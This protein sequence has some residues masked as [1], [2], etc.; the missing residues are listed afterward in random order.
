MGV[1]QAPLTV[2][3]YSRQAV[4]RRI[5]VRASTSRQTPQIG[6]LPPA[7]S[8]ARS[9]MTCDSFDSGVYGVSHTGAGAACVSGTT[10]RRGENR[11]LTSPPTFTTPIG[12]LKL[13][14]S[15]PLLPSRIEDPAILERGTSNKLK[16]QSEGTFPKVLP[17]CTN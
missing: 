12:R 16:E 9:G 10:I 1:A 2:H 15:D 4:S 13:E 3:V 6:I 5:L 11:A 8:S 17:I 7:R 14:T